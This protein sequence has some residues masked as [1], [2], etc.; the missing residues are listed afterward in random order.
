MNLLCLLPASGP[1]QDLYREVAR[2]AEAEAR[3]EIFTNL[4]ALGR[5]LAEPLGGCLLLAVCA[6][7]REL[8]ALAGLRRQ[9]KDLPL[10]LVV[11]DDHE[12]TLSQGHSLEPRLLASLECPPEEV[13]AVVL[14]L[15]RLAAKKQEPARAAAAG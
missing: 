7:A 13:L 15:L 6:G 1:A 8:D 12:L 4:E 3:T 14:N 10:V 2:Q 5:R 9:L 11:P